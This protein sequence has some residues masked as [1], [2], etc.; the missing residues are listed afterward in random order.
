[1]LARGLAE[2]CLSCLQTDRKGRDHGAYLS[3]GS[4]QRTC[5]PESEEDAEAGRPARA[6]HGPSSGCDSGEAPCCDLD[7]H[8][9]RSLPAPLARS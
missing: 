3:G 4:A 2:G 9:V 6:R 8:L 7:E 5:I 1:M